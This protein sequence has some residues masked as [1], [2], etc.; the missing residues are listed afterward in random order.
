MNSRRPRNNST[1]PVIIIET[2]ADFCAPSPSMLILQTFMPKQTHETNIEGSETCIRET[3]QIILC[4]PEVFQQI[5]TGIVAS[6]PRG[7]Q[8]QGLRITSRDALTT[9][10]R[11]L[12]GDAMKRSNDNVKGKKNKTYCLTVWTSLMLSS[13]NTKTNKISDMKVPKQTRDQRE[14]RRDS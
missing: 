14:K 12:S 13:V 8:S 5:M 4:F 1:F 2:F 10:P 3:T 9:Q 7:I 11:C 6:S